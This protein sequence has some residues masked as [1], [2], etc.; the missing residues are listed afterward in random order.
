MKIYNQSVTNTDSINC[1]FF[2]FYMYFALYML[3]LF[4]TLH[5][6]NEVAMPPKIRG[7]LIRET[8]MP[9]NVSR[10]EHIMTLPMSMKTYTP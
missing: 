3:S 6:I 9:L 8:A 2:L 1:K 10:A 4:H 5:F 7:R